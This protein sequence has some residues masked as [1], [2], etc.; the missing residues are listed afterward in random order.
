[1]SSRI[2]DK[3][4]SPR[5][6]EKTVGKIYSF[7]AEFLSPN[8]KTGVLNAFTWHEQDG[9]WPQS[10]RLCV[11]IPDVLGIFLLL[12]MN[13]AQFECRRVKEVFNDN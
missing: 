7:E 4:S 6:L 3:S 12:M 1:M 9:S 2:I 11:Q 5:R 13:T 8:K 10:K